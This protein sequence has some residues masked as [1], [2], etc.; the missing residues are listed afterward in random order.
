MQHPGQ[1]VPL[2]KPQPRDLTRVAYQIKTN[3]EFKRFYYDH[4]TCFERVYCVAW[5]Q[6]LSFYCC[7]RGDYR[8]DPTS[9]WNKTLEEIEL[10][11]R[12][13]NDLYEDLYGYF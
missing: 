3:N 6:D 10:Y 4:G 2:R 1:W 12:Q 7:P 13:K 9:G 11:S 8:Y 5:S